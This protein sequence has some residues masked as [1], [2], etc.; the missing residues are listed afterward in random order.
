MSLLWISITGLQGGH[1]GMDIH[2]GLDTN[3]L[4]SRLLYM[5]LIVMV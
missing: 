3:K 2:K 5:D 1:S 4:M